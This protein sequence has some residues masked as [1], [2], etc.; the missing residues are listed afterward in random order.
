MRTGKHAHRATLLLFQLPIST[1]HCTHPNDAQPAVQR[2][3][4]ICTIGRK[5][6]F[7][8]QNLY[9]KITSR[10][11]EQFNNADELYFADT[12]KAGPVQGGLLHVLRCWGHPAQDPFA[13]VSSSISSSPSSVGPRKH[14]KPEVTPRLEHV[15]AS[16]H[17]A[18]VICQTL[19]Q[20]QMPDS[21]LSLE[22]LRS[23]DHLSLAGPGRMV[24]F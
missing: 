3:S 9:Y 10:S 18:A 1:S 6:G 16:T 7:R 19:D 5:L 20:V 11:F 23:R 12:N 4:F 24:S 14:T 21:G 17:N 22:E 15:W 2:V 8:F 13:T